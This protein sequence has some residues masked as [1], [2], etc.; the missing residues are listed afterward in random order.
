MLFFVDRGKNF[1]YN[2]G[3]NKSTSP[4]IRFYRNFSIQLLPKRAKK[5]SDDS[6]GFFAS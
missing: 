5:P 1:V 4:A 3:V 6:L 2:G